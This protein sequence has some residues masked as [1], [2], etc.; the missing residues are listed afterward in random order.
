MLLGLPRGGRLPRFTST[1]ITSLAALEQELELIRERGYADCRGEFES[2]AWGV[3]APVLDAAG[4][5]A[6]GVV[7]LWGPPDRITADR[8]APLGA[9]A[10]EGAAAIAGRGAPAEVGA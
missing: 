6:V 10:I 9:I 4:R 1:T 8:F 5:R 3:S 7:S 2:S